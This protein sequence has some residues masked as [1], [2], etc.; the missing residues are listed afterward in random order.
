MT[1]KINSLLDEIKALQ[2]QI[3]T[4]DIERNATVAKIEQLQIDLTNLRK[5]RD[6]LEVIQNNA[7][8]M[9]I[10]GR[11]TDAEFAAN[12]RKLAELYSEIDD[13]DALLAI[14]E[15]ALDVDLI[16]RH[17]E[18]INKERHKKTIL[19]NQYAAKLAAEIVGEHAEKLKQLAACLE[20]AQGNPLGYNPSHLL[21]LSIASALFGE[22]NGNP[23]LQPIA[24]RTSLVNDT[25]QKLG[26]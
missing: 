13:K 18:L 12:K 24:E 15:K 21:G 19:L 17:S 4:A 23:I 7:S 5:Q 2:Q 6:K 14:Y 11:M 3:L 9:L 10:D 25:F 26:V 8:A 20:H 22:R 1:D 16:R